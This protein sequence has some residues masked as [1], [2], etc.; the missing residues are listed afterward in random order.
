MNSLTSAF[1]DVMYQYRLPFSPEGVEANLNVWNENKAP[2]LELLRRHPNWNEQELAV[3][4]DFSEG[5][6]IDH[7]SV[8]ENKFEMLMLAQEAG[9]SDGDLSDFQAA[10]NAATADYATVPDVSRLETIRA[11]GRIKCA[12]GQKASRII[13]RLCVKFGL[14]Q[15]QVQRIQGE[16]SDNPTSV[17]VKPYNSVFARLADSLNP[18]Q[19]PKTGILSVHPC[20]FLEMSSKKNTWYSCHRLNGGGYCV[21]CQ[22]YMG[23]DVSMIF[24]TVDE[25]IKADF[26]RAPRLTR[27]IFCYKN[28]MLLQSRLYPR[29]DGETQKLYRGIVQGAI[30]R[31]LGVPNLWN[32]KTSPNEFKSFLK[33]CEDSLHYPDYKNDYGT[34]SLLNGTPL[35][36]N[37][38][39]GSRSLCTC[40]GRPHSNAS[41]LKCRACEPVVVCKECGKSVSQP[42]AHYMNEAYYCGE[43][44]L[45][46]GACG[47][48]V[49]SAE[50]HCVTDRNGITLHLCERCYESV[51]GSCEQC[52]SH[53]ICQLVGGSRFC[54]RVD[55]VAADAA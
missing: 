24:F 32:I 51:T 7:N 47:T 35:E 13:N 17:S 36:E 23:D 55:Y 21:G 40:C 6:G 14:D 11:R 22:S 52:G 3:V 41:S 30:A 12:G 31:C 44:S 15:Y 18:I 28:G 9:L 20:D 50:T 49:H 2:L 5:R 1:Y 43:C 45:R 53:V 10:L 37:L 19:I 27:Q 33:T 34:V 46:C 39:I 38:T 48:W 29:N 42:T 4:F 25:D 16:H 8:D 54:A 26:Y